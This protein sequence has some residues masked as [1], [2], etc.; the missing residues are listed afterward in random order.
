MLMRMLGFTKKELNDG[1][2]NTFR[3]E[4]SKLDNRYYFSTYDLNY[5]QDS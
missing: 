3:K 1:M 5:F 4:I 2:I